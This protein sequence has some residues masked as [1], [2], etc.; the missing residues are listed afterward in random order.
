M[1][2]SFRDPLHGKLWPQHKRIAVFHVLRKDRLVSYFRQ[3][4]VDLVYVF[5]F[6]TVDFVAWVYWT[7]HT[8]YYMKYTPLSI[9]IFMIKLWYS[10]G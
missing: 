6:G 10:N 7:H 5:L 4:V 2:V 9:N 8:P 1:Y 3:F